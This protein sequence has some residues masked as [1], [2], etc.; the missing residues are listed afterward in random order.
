M[1]ILGIFGILKSLQNRWASMGSLGI[2][3]IPR[4]LSDKKTS[5]KIEKHPGA[6]KKVQVKS[7]HELLGFETCRCLCEAVH[8]DRRDAAWM[9][10]YVD[11]KGKV[12]GGNVTL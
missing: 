10:R 5:W 2:L 7:K 11:E 8:G 6:I 3:R 12:C 9:H 1:G 4:S